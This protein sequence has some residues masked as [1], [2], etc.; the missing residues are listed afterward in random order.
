[1]SFYFVKGLNYILSVKEYVPSP[2][3]QDNETTS[4]MILRTN[5]DATKIGGLAR[6]PMELIPT[7]ILLISYFFFFFN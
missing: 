3:A 2:A 6:C 1:M 4:P 7:E 5:I